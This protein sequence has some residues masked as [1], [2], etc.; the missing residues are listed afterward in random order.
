MK[1]NRFTKWVLVVIALAFVGVVTYG[2]ATDC[3]GTAG[4]YKYCGS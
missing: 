2:V 4:L 3:P 1:I